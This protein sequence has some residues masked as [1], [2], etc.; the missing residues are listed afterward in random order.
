VGIRSDL[1]IA[2]FG[3]SYFGIIISDSVCANDELYFGWHMRTAMFADRDS[4][5]FATEGIGELT[6]S[7]IR[8]A[9]AKALRSVESSQRR[10]ANAADS[11]KMNLLSFHT[12]AILAIYSI[13]HK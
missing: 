2:P 1:Y 13:I 5:S 10:D 4:H 8:T 6:L 9:H 12:T 7:K 11:D 3:F